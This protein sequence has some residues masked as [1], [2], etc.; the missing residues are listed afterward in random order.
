MNIFEKFG[1]RRNKLSAFEN[2][3]DVIS[4]QNIPENRDQLR[5]LLYKA[6][7]DLPVLD[8]WFKADKYKDV[9]DY[10]ISVGCHYYYNYIPL[11]ELGLPVPPTKKK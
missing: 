6:D 10:I 3:A 11:Q 4:I 5:K 2:Q 1:K 7:C 8:N 9:R